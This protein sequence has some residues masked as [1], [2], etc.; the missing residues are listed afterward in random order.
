MNFEADGD[1]PFELEMRGMIRIMHELLQGNAAKYLDPR[2]TCLVVLSMN[3]GL[4]LMFGSEISSHFHS[5]LQVLMCTAFGRL[6]LQIQQ[7]DMCSKLTSRHVRVGLANPSDVKMHRHPFIP[8]LSSFRFTVGFTPHL[9]S[10]LLCPF[11][12]M[13]VQLSFVLSL[14]DGWELPLPAVWRDRSRRT[15]AE[16]HG[17]LSPVEAESRGTGKVVNMPADYTL[18]G[19]SIRMITGD[20]VEWEVNVAKPCLARAT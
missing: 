14:R 5:K 2:D 1:V 16:T 13:R 10:N 18:N 11:R 3:F 9:I 20:L 12:I 7:V 19:L 17:R 15:Q 6:Y 4:W 8:I